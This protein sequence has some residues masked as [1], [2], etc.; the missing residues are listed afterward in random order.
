MKQFTL[1]SGLLVQVRV[2]HLV[3]WITGRRPGH[4]QSHYREVPRWEI[5]MGQELRFGL[6]LGLLA[7]LKKKA[8]LEGVFF[9]FSGSKK[10]FYNFL[11][12]IV[13]STLKSCIK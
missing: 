12:N 4:R 9:M 8:T 5:F 2:C 13:A 10:K 7:V 11:K 1:F 6:S 3:G